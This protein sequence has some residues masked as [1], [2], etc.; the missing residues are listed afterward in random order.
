MTP[1]VSKNPREAFLNYRETDIGTDTKGE[2]KGGEIYGIK[3]FKH[4][5]ERLVRIKTK[6]DPDNFFRNEQSIPTLSPKV[7]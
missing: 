4:N 5:F 1:H 7:L 6:I 3:Y 2:Y